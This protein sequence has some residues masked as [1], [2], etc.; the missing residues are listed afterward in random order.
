[1]GRTNENESVT[2][3]QQTVEPDHLLVDNQLSDPEE[4]KDSHNQPSDVTVHHQQITVAHP[5]CAQRITSTTDLPQS[6]AAVTHTALE[7]TDGEK[8]SHTT[9]PTSTSSAELSS[10]ATSLEE[11]EDEPIEEPVG[12]VRKLLW[13]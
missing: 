7:P 11:E 5:E 4:T 10:P 8:Q 1:N 13:P 3:E 2:L 12:H 9:E 6:E